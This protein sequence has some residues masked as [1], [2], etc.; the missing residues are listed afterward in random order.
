MNARSSLGTRNR[1]HGVVLVISLLMLL[2]LTMIGVAATRSTTLEQRMTT[3]QND[4]QVA[5]E[6]AEAALRSG[7][8]ALSNS[9][10]VN[11]YASNTA[12]AYMLNTMTVNW[13]TINWDASGGA[14]FDYTGL[15]PNTLI[16]PTY[17][18]VENNITGFIPGRNI[19]QGQ[20]LNNTVIY[21][22]YAR[23]VGLS[24]NNAVVL[25]SVYEMQ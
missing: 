9:I 5:F 3:N 15:Q 18:V 19:V 4:Q 23:G 12:G 10:P 21:Y 22:V 14:V 6:A 24:S 20:P 13:R 1:Q 25:E 17:F 16:D 11:A 7:E 8:S 2:V